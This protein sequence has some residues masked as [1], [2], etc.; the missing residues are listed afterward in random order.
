[1]EALDFSEL[2]SVTDEELEHYHSKAKEYPAL[3]P[4]DAATEY[5]A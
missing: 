3:L 4:L 1:M 5:N 2:I